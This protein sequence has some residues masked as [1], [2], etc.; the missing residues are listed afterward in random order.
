MHHFI[1]TTFFIFSLQFIIASVSGQQKYNDSL[2]LIISEIENSNIYEMSYTV[3]Y[4]GTISKQYL[5]FKQLLQLA[6]GKQLSELAVNH[7]NAVVRLYAYQALKQK[8]VPIPENIVV[9][10]TNDHTFVKTLWGCF[11]AVR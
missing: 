5:R 6:T 9:Y 11:G 7:N 10:F 4:A 1:K 8:S 2:I 3:G